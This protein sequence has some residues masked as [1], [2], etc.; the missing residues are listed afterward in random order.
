M[1]ETEL[2]AQRC[3]YN[4]RWGVSEDQ[5]RRAAREIFGSRVLK[6]KISLTPRQCQLRQELKELTQE[7][8][9]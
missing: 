5:Q 7:S 6:R 9:T 8:S 2:L 3:G 1:N 4:K